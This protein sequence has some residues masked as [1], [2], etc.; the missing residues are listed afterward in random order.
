MPALQGQFQ[1]GTVDNFQGREAAVSIVSMTTTSRD[2]APRGL[3]F[4]LNPNRL[5][6]AVSRAQSLAIVLGSPALLE[7]QCGSVEEL[8]LVNNLSHAAA[9]LEM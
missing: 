3:G 2:D 4:V 6:V 8:R 1:I 7:T 9:R 5:N